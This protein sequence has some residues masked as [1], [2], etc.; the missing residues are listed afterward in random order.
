LAKVLLTENNDMIEA[1]SAEIDPSLRK[2]WSHLIAEPTLT[3]NCSAAS[4]RDPPASTKSI[5][6]ILNALG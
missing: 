2:C 4:R 5:S 1:V 3:S 6:R